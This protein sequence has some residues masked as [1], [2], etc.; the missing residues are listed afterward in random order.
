MTQVT[1][2]GMNHSIGYHLESDCGLL[3]RELVDDDMLVPTDDTGFRLPF[4]VTQERKV[5]SLR[6]H[7]DLTSASLKG[8]Q[9]TVARALSS[10]AVTA[11]WASSPRSRT[12]CSQT[13][14]ATSSA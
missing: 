2:N 10:E 1:T 11:M 14:R 3:G 8:Q 5:E 13:A 9:R 7:F 12:W 6:R 4:V